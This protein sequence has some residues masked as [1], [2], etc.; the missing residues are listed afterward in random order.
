MDSVR[1]HSPAIR[2]LLR[3][4][5][6]KVFWDLV[7]EELPSLNEGRGY[8]EL[9]W[10]LLFGTWHDQDTKRLLLPSDL[11]CSFEGRSVQNSRAEAFLV[12]FREN[13]IPH[14]GKF[15]WSRWRKNKCRQLI[16]LH[17]GRLRPFVEAEYE[18]RWHKLG[19]VYLD[20][21][22]FSPATMRYARRQEF[23]AV[24]PHNA[25]CDEAEFIRSYL[26]NLP[27]H[28][29]TKCVRNNYSAARLA[30]LKLRNSAVMAEQL[31]LLRCIEAQPQPFYGPSSE[32]NTIRLFTGSSIPNLQRDVRK[33]LTA[34]WVD[35]DLRC[36][37]LAIC[38]ALWN[39][40]PINNFLQSGE[41]FWTHVLHAIGVPQRNW[42]VAKRE[43]KPALYSICYGMDLRHVKGT[44]ALRLTKAGLDKHI[45][46]RFV[47][48]PLVQALLKAR[49]EA[50]N[51]IA[52]AGG[53]MTC[54][55]KRCAVSEVRQ[56]RRIMAEV[57]QALELKL[58]YPAFRLAAETQE[59]S[60]VLFQ[61]DGFSLHFRRRGEMWLARIAG[62]IQEEAIQQGIAT[63]LEWEGQSPL[64]S[65]SMLKRNVTKRQS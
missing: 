31:R 41:N 4:I 29:F 56:P 15:V 42:E 16:N 18:M 7:S 27:P 64:E 33:S 3:R 46:T 59:F 24:Q 45:A 62:V 40:E 65:R 36:S 39:V 30:A 58:I 25:Y 22:T 10:Y 37:Q 1:I 47:N 34:D 54:F 13:V 32:G 9:F 52:R 21:R 61:H 48:H 35:V 2:D 5:T 55:G 44:T 43:I 53:A 28:L 57:A 63:R 11:L 19:R 50:L 20:G 8:R 23:E 14:D 51:S 17:F 12:R 26:N 49:E 38:A 6:V 60:I